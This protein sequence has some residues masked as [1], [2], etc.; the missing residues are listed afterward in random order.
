MIPITLKVKSQ[1]NPESASNSLK[2]TSSLPNLLAVFE[3]DD[4]TL[5]L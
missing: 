1:S 4:A 5:T 2:A 3:V